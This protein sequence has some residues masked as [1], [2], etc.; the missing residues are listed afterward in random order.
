MMT[1]MPKGPAPRGEYAGKSSVF[2]TRIRPDLRQSLEKAARR[3]GRSLSQEVEYRLRRSFIE[4]DKIADAFGDRQTYRLMRMM[5]DAIHFSQLRSGQ[6]EVHW[7]TNSV[8]F[9]FAKEA[10]AAIL[11][12]VAPDEKPS[13]LPKALNDRVAQVVGETTAAELWLNVVAAPVQLPL[14]KGSR[15]DH[16]Y[17]I[18]KT[19]LR[20]LLGRAITEA[21]QKRI[22]EL[23]DLARAETDAVATESGI[24][25]QVAE[26]REMKKRSRGDDK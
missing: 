25:E 24:S 11:E 22:R 16:R 17:S 3:S 20:G 6:P 21:H 12:R 18:A 13:S 1:T 5:T 23:V 10:I 2:S 15:E 26:M 7:L 8:T 14:S 19:D 9:R 4:D